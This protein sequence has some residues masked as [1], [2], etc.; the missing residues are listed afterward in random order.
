MNF[1]S[2]VYTPVKYLDLPH[3]GELLQPGYQYIIP[4]I[5]RAMVRD[6]YGFQIPEV[7]I[8]MHKKTGETIITTIV[9]NVDEATVTST[10]TRNEARSATFYFYARH[11]KTLFTLDCE[12][13]HDAVLR[14]RD[15]EKVKE[16]HEKAAPKPKKAKEVVFVDLSALGL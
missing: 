8:C 15:A 11:K 14:T 10:T 6:E 1:T 4:P 9:A 5:A 12:R 16:E 7:C 3:R 2:S 13:V